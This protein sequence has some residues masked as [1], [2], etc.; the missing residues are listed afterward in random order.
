MNKARR[1]YYSQFIEKENSSNQ[2]KLFRESK[3]LL[4]IQADKILPPH[5]DAVKLANDDFVRKVTAVRFKLAASIQAPSSAVQKS[6]SITTK[7]Y[8]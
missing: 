1:S 6:D 5:T 2:S 7:P 8:P 4:N 3:C